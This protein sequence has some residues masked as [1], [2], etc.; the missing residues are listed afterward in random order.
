ML[1]ALL[2]LQKSIKLLVGGEDKMLNSEQIKDIIVAS[3]NNG[4]I[5]KYNDP[6]KFAEIIAKFEKAYYEEESK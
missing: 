5:P 1:G 2:N 3:L 4:Y 6:E